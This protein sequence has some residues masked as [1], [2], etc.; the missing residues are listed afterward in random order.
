MASLGNLK[1]RIESVAQLPRNL[2][3]ER[4]ENL[5]DRIERPLRSGASPRA[6]YFESKR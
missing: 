3:A 1:D 4:G 2:E 5:K 6:M